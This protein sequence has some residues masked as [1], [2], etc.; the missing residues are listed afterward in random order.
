MQTSFDDA[1]A[2]QE[3][4]APRTRRR[5]MPTTWC[6]GRGYCVALER[7]G[8][9]L[10]GLASSP[11]LKGRCMPSG[12]A[13][14]LPEYQ[15]A[16]QVTRDRHVPG[17]HAANLRQ[18]QMSKVVV[19]SRQGSNLLYL[20]LTNSCMP[21]PA[22]RR[23]GASIAGQYGASQRYGEQSVCLRPMPSDAR[24]ARRHRVSARC[25]LRRERHESHRGLPLLRCWC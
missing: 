4:N 19:D 3:R 25:T 16:P 2:G 23:P 10:T 20:P 6:R 12:S 18:C 17:H 11:R 21:V 5:P 9:V 24:A 22:P 15:K 1:L 14:V 7:R 13:A 8:E